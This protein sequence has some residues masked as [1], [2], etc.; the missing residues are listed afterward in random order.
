MNLTVVCHLCQCS[1]LEDLFFYYG[2]DI[3]LQAHEGCYERMYP[4]M[5]GVLLSENYTNPQAPVQ[6][7]HGYV[8]VTSNNIDNTNNTNNNTTTL[9]SRKKIDFDPI[10]CNKFSV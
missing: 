7:V 10:K 8:N 1:R 3:V 2:V 4:L 9:N 6:I 5:K